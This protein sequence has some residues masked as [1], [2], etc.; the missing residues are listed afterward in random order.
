MIRRRVGA[1]GPEVSA[2]GLGC[3][4]MS[5]A[6][7]GAD[8]AEST[9]TLHRALDLGV[10]HLDTADMYGFGANERLLAPVVRARRDEVFLATKFGNRTTGD[11][12]AGTGTPGAYVDSSAAWA[13]QACDASLDRLGVDTIDLYYLHRRNPETPIEETV[14]AMAELVRAGKVRLIGLSEVSPAT[15][16]AAH[17]VH[18]IAAVQIEYS[19]FS[20]DVEGEMLATCRELG[21]SLVAYSPVG[22]G[23]LTGT[24]TSREQLAGDDWRAGAPRFAEGNLGANLKLVDQVRAIAG[25]VGAT[26][27]QVA[28]AW[29]LAEGDDILPIPGTK[30][31]RYLE[32]NAAAADLRLTPEQ[33]ARLGEA[34][35]PGAVAGERYPEAAMRF[36]GR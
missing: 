34:V 19:L 36:I 22:R 25:E 3:M 29:L 16:R 32:E 2:I 27:A 20:R 30:R 23:L 28:L 13:R 31:V 12:F 4:G 33:L 10:N 14:G 26:P 18:P 17:A 6:Y 15:L 1:T 9:R 7:G 24:I 8:D 35:P 21:V 5:F 11:S